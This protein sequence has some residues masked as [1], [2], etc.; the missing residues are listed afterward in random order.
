LLLLCAFPLFAL[1]KVSIQLKWDHMFQF[2][3]YYAAVEQGYYRD[4][5]FTFFSLSIY[6]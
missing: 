6:I 2:A 1:D 5:G 3:G 4:E